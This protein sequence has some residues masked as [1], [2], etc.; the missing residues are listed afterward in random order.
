[1][2]TRFILQF[3]VLILLLVIPL[4]HA[5]GLD[6]ADQRLFQAQ[7]SVAEKGNARAQYYLGEMYEQGLGTAQNLDEAFKWYA[8]AAQQGDPLAKNKM[9]MRAEIEADAKIEQNA[10]TTKFAPASQEP[11]L[12][13]DVTANDVATVK[14]ATP[15]AALPN[16]KN[17]S[18]EDNNIKAAQ[19]AAQKAAEKEKRRA[20]VRAMITDRLRHPV[21][22]PFQ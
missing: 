21:G 5:A 14:P 15:A 19:L 17:Q 22:E 20:M 10:D 4:V 13:S 11:D 6:D 12:F 1:M 9:D 16:K 7:R 3:P 18:G 2:S 8:R